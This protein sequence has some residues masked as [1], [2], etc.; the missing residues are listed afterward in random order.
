M[1]NPFR[2]M[3][4]PNLR[5]VG[6]SVF[7]AQRRQTQR[8]LMSSG[9]AGEEPGSFWA[10]WCIPDVMPIIF[11]LTAGCGFSAFIIGKNGMAHEDVTWIKSEKKKGVAGRYADKYPGTESLTRSG[12]KKAEHH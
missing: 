5:A 4:A 6:R 11:C 9:A 2:A 10:V 12:P 3:I 1:M 8:R 7:Q